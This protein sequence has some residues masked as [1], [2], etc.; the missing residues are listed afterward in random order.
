[1]GNEMKRVYVYITDIYE[2]VHEWRSSRMSA[3]AV[4]DR[5]SGLQMRF[6]GSKRSGRRQIDFD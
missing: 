2:N 3:E 4:T 5:R 1:M 6:V